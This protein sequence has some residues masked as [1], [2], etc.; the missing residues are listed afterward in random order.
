MGRKSL[1][2]QTRS[3]GRSCQKTSGGGHDGPSIVTVYA[4]HLHNMTGPPHGLATIPCGIKAR[5]TP[6]QADAGDIGHSLLFRK[7]TRNT[8]IYDNHLIYH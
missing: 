5:R 3:D 1:K 6:T 8:F 7:N 4:E 2:G